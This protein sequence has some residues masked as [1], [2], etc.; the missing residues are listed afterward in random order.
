MK[1]FLFLEKLNPLGVELP[2][3]AVLSTT[4]V[5]RKRPHEKV[6]DDQVLRAANPG[7]HPQKLRILIGHALEKVKNLQW[8][9]MRARE[10]TYFSVGSCKRTP[11]EKVE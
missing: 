2:G 11:L 5:T 9:K 4:I 7:V 10:E 8:Q 3:E 6:L 1:L